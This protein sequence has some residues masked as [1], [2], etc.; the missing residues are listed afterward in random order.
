MTPKDGVFN[1]AQ[2]VVNITLDTTNLSGIYT[3]NIKGMA[4][5]PKANPSKPYYPLNGQWSDVSSIQFTVIKQTGDATGMVR[6]ILGNNIS[7]A[8][9]FT[10][11]TF[12]T[13]TDSNGLYS[14]TLPVG[15]YRLTASKEPQY[16]PNSSVV[17][18]VLAFTT[19]TVDIILTPKPT[20]TIR[21]NVTIK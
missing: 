21:G 14:L 3:V 1:Y 19:V 12:S 4:S 11:T 8:I 15:T 6:G 10:N 16:Y 18:N 9:V 20:G 13:I 2:E 5:G 17:V 7:G